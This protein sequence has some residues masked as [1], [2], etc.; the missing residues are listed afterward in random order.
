[1]SEA[2]AGWERLEGL[3]PRPWACR[4]QARPLWWNARRRT[5]PALG[6]QLQALLEHD[7][8]AGNRIAQA[9]NGAGRAAAG[10]EWTG[11]RFGPYRVVREIGRG[12]MGLVFEAVRDDLEYRKKV[13]LKIAPW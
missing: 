1:M 2:S 9:V 8:I 10:P 4:R 12:G 6:R 11:R 13:A 7:R 5:T 3:S